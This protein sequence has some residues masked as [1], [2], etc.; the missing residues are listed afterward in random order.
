MK[1]G[2]ISKLA[3]SAIVFTLSSAAFAGGDGSC[4]E[5]KDVSLKILR[6]S[7]STENIF[8]NA[9]KK[10]PV[11]NLS[12]GFSCSRL[13]SINGVI[14]R[15]NP[16]A[17]RVIVTG[18]NAETGETQVMS[19]VPKADGTFEVNLAGDLDMDSE[20]TVSVLNIETPIGAFSVQSVIV[21][22]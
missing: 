17:H 8:G 10:N 14:M 16:S 4:V 13:E 6:P 20:L 9:A 5:K 21:S 11:E 3:I 15:T 19:G 7:V 18:K 1:I 2:R 12:I 22:K